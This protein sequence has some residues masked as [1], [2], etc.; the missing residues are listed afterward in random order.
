MS[1]G[2]R[3]CLALSSGPIRDHASLRDYEHR[4]L[5]RVTWLHAVNRGI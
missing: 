3:G 4:G 1:A 5:T 2:A